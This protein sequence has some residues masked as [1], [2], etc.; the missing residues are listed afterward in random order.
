MRRKFWGEEN[1]VLLKNAPSTVLP[2]LIGAD[3]IVTE[4]FVSVCRLKKKRN[5]IMPVQ[6]SAP[7]LG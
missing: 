6:D 2:A 1:P 3:D 7:T 4:K 5:T